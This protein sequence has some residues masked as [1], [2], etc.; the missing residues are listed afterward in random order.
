M[1]DPD[2]DPNGEPVGDPDGE[3]V[4][5]LDGEPVGEPE[6]AAL[7]NRGSLL[8]LGVSIPDAKQASSVPSTESQ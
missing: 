4:G 2:G 5:D 7:I 1:G 6:G 8:Q 3:P